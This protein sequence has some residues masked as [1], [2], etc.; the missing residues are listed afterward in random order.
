MDR[1]K[2]LIFGGAAIATLGG[3]QWSNPFDRGD[4]LRVTGLLGALPSKVISQFE[5]ASQKKTEYKAENL[6]A[7]LWQELQN[8]RHVRSAHGTACSC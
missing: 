3:C 2:F 1:R 6:P 7:K 5:S 8:Y 4:R